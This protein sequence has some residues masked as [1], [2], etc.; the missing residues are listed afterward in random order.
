MRGEHQT[1]RGRA[2]HQRGLTPTCVGSTT[3]HSTVRPTT[4]THPHVRGEHTVAIPDRPSF[5]DSP[6][7]AW[8][9]LE[10]GV[11]GRRQGGLTP[12]CVGST[13][14]SRT[15]RGNRRTHPHVRGEHSTAVRARSRIDRDSPPRAWGARTAAPSP[16]DRRGLTPTCVGSTNASVV[17]G[18]VTGTHPHVRGEHL[19]ARSAFEVPEDSPPRAWG[20]RRVGGH[21]HGEPGL[22]PTCVGST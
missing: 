1:V 19:M 16:G 15:Q 22:T 2:D 8:G 10:V 21:D 13:S 20:A 17:A 5:V 3:P 4:W 12:T 6:P 11:V 18:D 9:A 7:R 14:M